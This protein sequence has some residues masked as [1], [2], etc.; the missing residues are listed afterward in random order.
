MKVYTKK[1]DKGETSLIGGKRVKKYHVRIDAY[2]TVDELNSFI[3]LIRDSAREKQADADLREIQNRLF[4]V[5]SELA[6]DPEKKN[7]KI[8]VL[9]DADI[10]MLERAIDRMDEELEPLKNFIL[11]GGDITASHCHVARCVCR[12][13]ERI[14]NLLAEEEE[15]DPRIL[16]YLNRLSDYLFVLARFYTKKHGGEETLWKTRTNP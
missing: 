12:R 14:A 9:H 8:P 2:G 3:G 7:V 16:S 15:T 6:T 5:G 10:E 4:T 13:A 11:P 1:G